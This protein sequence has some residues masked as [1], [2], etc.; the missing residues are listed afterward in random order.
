[1]ERVIFSGS[2]KDFF[3]EAGL[4]T[5]EDFFNYPGPERETESSN[6]DVYPITIN[7]GNNSNMFFIKRFHCPQID[8]IFSTWHNFGK[9]ITQAKVEWSNASLL[10]SNNINTYKPVCFGE[11]TIWGIERKSFIVTEQLTST[12]FKEFVSQRWLELE[13]PHQ[14]KIITAI[15]KLIRKVHDLNI[16]FPDLYVWHIFISQ[17]SINNQCQ[18]SFIDLHRMRRNIKNENEKIKNLGRLFWSMSPKYF[19]DGL[20]E[21]FVN[22]YISDGQ[23]TDKAAL[24]SRIKKYENKL[25]SR[26]NRKDY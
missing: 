18:L 19:D 10:E 6:R 17:D 23:Q 14:E 11:R 3:A 1:V 25:T 12:D 16:S 24:T 8:D 5:F 4:A 7:K 22:A 20:K 15:A 13:R 2:W 26:R 9:F 21:L